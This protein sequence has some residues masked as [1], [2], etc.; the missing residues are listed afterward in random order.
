MILISYLFFKIH[1][2]IVKLLSNRFKFINDIVIVF[3]IAIL[4]KIFFFEFSLNFIFFTISFILIIFDLKQFLPICS[5]FL[6]LKQR[7][8]IIVFFLIESEFDVQIVRNT[9]KINDR[10]NNFNCKIIFEVAAIFI[11]IWTS[12]FFVLLTFIAIWYR[13][14]LILMFFA[15]FYFS[16]VFFIKVAKL[17]ISI[18]LSHFTDKCFW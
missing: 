11:S 7:F 16:I 15:V 14:V 8:S 1:F 13:C 9:N 3:F 5:I 2:A 17:C 6:Q 12:M 18:I 4:I 10:L